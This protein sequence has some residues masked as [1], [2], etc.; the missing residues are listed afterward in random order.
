[1]HGA[2]VNVEERL[3]GGAVFAIRFST[4]LA[5]ETVPARRFET[6]R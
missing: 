2:T 3:G 4:V 6:V 5:S 1:M